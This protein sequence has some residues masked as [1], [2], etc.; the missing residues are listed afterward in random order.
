MCDECDKIV[1]KAMQNMR[2]VMC[3]KKEYIESLKNAIGEM[4]VEIEA[5]DASEDDDD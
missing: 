5:T 4:Q 1:E 2:R 3:N